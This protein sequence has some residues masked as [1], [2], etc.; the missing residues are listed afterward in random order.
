MKRTRRRWTVRERRGRRE[1]PFYPHHVTR[2]AMAMAAAIAVLTALAAVY[3]VPLE[4]AADPL[5]APTEGVPPEIFWALKP[6]VVIDLL[7]PFGALTPLILLAATAVLLALPLM[8]RSGETALR[9]RLPVA[10]PF[11]L[12]MAYVAVSLWL[13]PG[14]VMTVW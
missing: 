8:D 4:Q 11:A 14:K 1:Y 10:I 6:L 12:I 7:A 2:N 3:P 13:F 9:R 5:A